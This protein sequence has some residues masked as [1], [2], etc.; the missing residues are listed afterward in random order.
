MN[1][2]KSAIA[3]DANDFP[4]LNIAGQVRNNCIGIGKIGGVFAAGVQLG[5]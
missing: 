2:P 3:K 5:H 1:S 4:A